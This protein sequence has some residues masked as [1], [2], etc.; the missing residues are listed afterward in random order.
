MAIGQ[1]LRT[2]DCHNVTLLLHCQTQP[3]L[4]TSSGIRLG[5]CQVF[6]KQLLDQ[7]HSAKLSPWNNEWYHVFD[8]N[9]SSG[10]HWQLL[11]R[12]SI[13]RLAQEH[14]AKGPET[15]E[16]I[17]LAWSTS[18]KT[19]RQSLPLVCAPK[20]ATTQDQIGSNHLMLVGFHEA[21]DQKQLVSLLFEHDC[22]LGRTRQLPTDAKR[23]SSVLQNENRTLRRLLHDCQS[24]VAFEVQSPR[25]DGEVWEAFVKQLESL[26]PQTTYFCKDA[27]ERQQLQL[28]LFAGKE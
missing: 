23:W 4:E 28:F 20:E 14:F 11:D 1:Q 18:R 8:F 16:D 22:D 24:I 9:A 17:D 7:M 15:G 10:R 13:D 5:Y 12:D 6:Y 2:R 19:V 21:Q 27:S 3:S 25:T 26:F